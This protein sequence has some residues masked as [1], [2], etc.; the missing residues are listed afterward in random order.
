MTPE[1]V[2]E[3]RSFLRKV[4]DFGKLSGGQLRD[5]YNCDPMEGYEWLAKQGRALHAKIVAAEPAT[6]D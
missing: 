6:T 1:L 5:K 3:M 4:E 2:R